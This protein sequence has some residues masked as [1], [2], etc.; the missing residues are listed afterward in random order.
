MGSALDSGAW[1]GLVLIAGAGGLL[2]ALS[3]VPLARTRMTPELL[4]R[5]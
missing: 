2:A 3:T 5:E 4:R 1:L